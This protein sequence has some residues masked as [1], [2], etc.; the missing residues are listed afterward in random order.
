[1]GGTPDDLYG[2]T[3]DAELIVLRDTST[4]PSNVGEITRNGSAIKMKDGSGV[5]NVRY[6]SN[7]SQLTG[8]VTANGPGSVSAVLTSGPNGGINTANN[9]G[10]IILAVNT[11]P[12]VNQAQQSPAFDVPSAGSFTLPTGGGLVDGRRITFINSST[13]PV[14]ITGGAGI[15]RTMSPKG[16]STWVYKLSGTL[17]C[18]TSNV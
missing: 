12:T 14:T 17:W 18:C 3:T 13:G 15:S 9:L 11:A 6:G 5:F 1:M 2:G 7:I 10:L 4:D 16:G 8:D